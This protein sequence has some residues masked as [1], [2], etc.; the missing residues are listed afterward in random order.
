MDKN[1]INKKAL[2]VSGGWEGHEPELT[3]PLF[4][5]TLREHGFEVVIAETLDAF[6]DAESLKSYQLIVP[7]WTMGCP[8][9]EQIEN[10]TQAIH[11]GVGLGGFHG[12]MGD[13]FR[14]CTEYEWMVGG[15]FAG[16]PHVGE[17]TVDVIDSE[18]PITRGLPENFIYDSEQYYLLVD[19]G[20]TILADTEYSYEGQT[21][22]MP[23]VWTKHWGKGR[24]FY[25]ALGH[26]AAEFSDYPAVFEMTVRGL[27]WAASKD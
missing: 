6:D 9:P 15:H 4:A 1:P 3:T 10:L 27:L 12:G 17:Y 13:A 19:P 24:V 5:D 21:V 8:T 23:I 2:I 25:S 18:H 20:V 22:K 26:K 16:H 11:S 7:N 14:G